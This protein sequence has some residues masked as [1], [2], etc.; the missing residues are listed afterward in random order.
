MTSYSFSDIIFNR[1]FEQL[2]K[3]FDNVNNQCK[4]KIFD[5][6]IFISRKIINA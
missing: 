5:F 1:K 4:F 3:Y 6:L 2:M